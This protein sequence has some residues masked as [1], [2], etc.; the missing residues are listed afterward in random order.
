M[1][2]WR[3]QP[4]PFEGQGRMFVAYAWIVV[5]FVV[6]PTVASRLDDR[7]LPGARVVLV[8]VV[9]SAGSWATPCTRPCPGDAEPEP[10]PAPPGRWVL[11]INHTSHHRQPCTRCRSSRWCPPTIGASLRGSSARSTAAASPC[12]R[13][14]RRRTCTSP[15]SGDR[16]PPRVLRSTPPCS[17]SNGEGRP[18][19]ST[20]G[21]RSARSNR[22]RSTKRGAYEPATVGSRRR[23]SINA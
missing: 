10:S 16:V 12:S 1:N 14:R 22:S 4:N 20:I 18:S 19:P 6:G 15:R 5:L 23:S 17:G 7:G 3:E 21:W 8:L 13:G 2:L 9:L 11:R